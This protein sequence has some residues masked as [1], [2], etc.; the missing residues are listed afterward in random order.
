MKSLESKKRKV[1]AL[2]AENVAES[3]PD[4]QKLHEQVAQKA[5]ELY[6]KR[7]RTGECDVKDWVEAERLILDQLGSERST[8][9]ESSK[10][11]NRS[12]LL[13]SNEAR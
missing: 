13:R 12:K 2:H 9:K 11:A 1:N 10:K 5:Y 7:G 4:D 6:E 8:S 3:T